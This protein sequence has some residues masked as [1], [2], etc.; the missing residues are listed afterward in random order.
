MSPSGH[1]ASWTRGSW[2]NQL[3]THQTKDAF[4]LQLCT[5]GHRVSVSPGH[6]RVLGGHPRALAPTLV[7]GDL[8]GGGA[9]AAGAPLCAH[10]PPPQ[11]FGANGW[12]K[13]LGA[14]FQAQR[15]SAGEQWMLPPQHRL[16]GPLGAGRVLPPSPCQ[17][18]PA[19]PLT[20]AGGTGA[21]LLQIFSEMK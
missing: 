15:R 13:A 7:G 5:G 17:L 19:R 12:Q 16:W 6:L 4:A 10:H 20:H 18:H 21:P 11:D 2:F 1:P 8:Q 14:L 3:S 9:G